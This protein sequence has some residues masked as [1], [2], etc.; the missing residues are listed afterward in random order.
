MLIEQFEPR[1]VWW[2][3]MLFL[4]IGVC[5]TLLIW[6]LTIIPDG[7]MSTQWGWYLVW[8]ISQVAVTSA[9]IVVLIMPG[10]RTM[11]LRAR[12]DTAFGYLAVAWFLFLSFIIK[13]NGD[14]GNPGG[15]VTLLFYG[16]VLGS[17]LALVLI[18][19]ALRRSQAGKPEELF[20]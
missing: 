1:L 5:L 16:M 2:K 3:Q 20:P 17:G 8:L 14:N 15:L 18:Y 9:G 10:W 13:T 12:L 19:V 6:A 11:P 4:S 7:H